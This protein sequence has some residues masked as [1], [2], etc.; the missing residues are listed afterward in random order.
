MR[1][2]GGALG[3]GVG[4][5][6]ANATAVDDGAFFFD[7][8]SPPGLEALE[9]YLASLPETRPAPES[10][11]INHKAKASTKSASAAAP[12]LQPEPDVVQSTGP[13]SVPPSALPS[14]SAPR[15]TLSTAP[16]DDE[17]AHLAEG[18]SKSSASN[19]K[20]NGQVINGDILATAHNKPASSSSHAMEVD[21]TPPLFRYRNRASNQLHNSFGDL[22]PIHISVSNVSASSTSSQAV[23][24]PVGIDVENAHTSTSIAGRREQVSDAEIADLLAG[25]CISDGHTDD[26]VPAAQ[27]PAAVGKE[28]R[29]LADSPTSTTTPTPLMARSRLGLP[30]AV[31]GTA[32]SECCST[33]VKEDELLARTAARDLSSVALRFDLSN[34]SDG[35]SNVSAQ[36][37]R[38]GTFL[39]GHVMSIVQ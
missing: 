28:R 14:V 31:P 6:D 4:D 11:K 16:T 5:G 38:L 13:Q 39:L 22:S 33:P 20:S 34:G 24:I 27:A 9:S 25:L 18:A 17:N 10:P 26:A 36:R 30:V 15:Q 3:V 23:P 37:E 8:R 21:S 12:V 7:L 1:A 32:Y 35:A 2:I 29:L 19:A